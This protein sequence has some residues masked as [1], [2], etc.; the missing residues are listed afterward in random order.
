MKNIPHKFWFDSEGWSVDQALTWINEANRSP[1]KDSL[2]PF[3]GGL[4]SCGYEEDCSF[5]L[6][7]PSTGLI[8]EIHGSHCSCFDFEE[9][10][11]PELCPIEYI[12][13][14]KKWEDAYEITL[15]TIEYFK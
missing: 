7:E 13:K 4:N 1:I 8:Y 9:Q 6:F 5:L 2:I 15:K 11:N 10:F 14:G 12:Q 3:A